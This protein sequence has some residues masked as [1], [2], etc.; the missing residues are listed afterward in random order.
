MKGGED[1]GYVSAKVPCFYCFLGTG[2]ADA[3]PIHS[4]QM[5]L[6]EGALVNGAAILANCAVNWLRANR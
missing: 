4:P 3:Y 1:F 5:V 6:D 2:Q